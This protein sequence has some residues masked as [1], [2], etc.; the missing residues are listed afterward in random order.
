MAGE[1]LF[2]SLLQ[3]EIKSINA[4]AV[5]ALFAKFKSCFIMMVL[6]NN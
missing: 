1:G 5:A 3:D 6:V 4:D 2:R